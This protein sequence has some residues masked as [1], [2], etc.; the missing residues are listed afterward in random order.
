MDS[1]DYATP[2]IA[3]AV[4]QVTGEHYV[5]APNQARTLV[6][7]LYS[8][9]R[10]MYDCKQDDPALLALDYLDLLPTVAGLVIKI[11]KWSVAVKY[12]T[13]EELMESGAQ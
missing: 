11:E 2:G 3:R 9:V 5:N 4:H 1:Q 12:S 13:P 8:F 10:K 7:Q 6:E